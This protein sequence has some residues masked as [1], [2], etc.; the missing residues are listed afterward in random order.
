MIDEIA[1]K[2]K[3]RQ[4]SGLKNITRPLGS[5]DPNV[6]NE[7][8]NEKLAEL[9]NTNQ[10]GSF[11]GNQFKKVVLAS[12]EANTTTGRTDQKLAELAELAELAKTRLF[13]HG[14]FFFRSP[15]RE[16]DGTI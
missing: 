10:N 2:A 12:A 13:H 1:G 15:A 16:T 14:L 7:R 8:T 5:Q 4:L 11:K 9:A 6:E 3:E